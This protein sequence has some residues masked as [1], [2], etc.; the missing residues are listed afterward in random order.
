MIQLLEFYSWHLILCPKLISV[1]STIPSSIFFHIFMLYVLDLSMPKYLYAILGS[2]SL[3]FFSN[4]LPIY[5]MLWTQPF[6]KYS[7][8]LFSSKIHINIFA[9]CFHNF[10]FILKI[11]VII[12]I[13]STFMQGIYNYIPK[14]N[15]VSRVCSVAAVL[16]L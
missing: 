15:H 12:T 5:G 6:Q 14:P 2:I 4:V 10:Y 1:S 8:T 3:I 13:I 11:V 7:C 9:N 16:Y